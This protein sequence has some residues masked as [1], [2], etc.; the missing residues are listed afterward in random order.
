MVIGRFAAWLALV[1]VRLTMVAGPFHLEAYTPRWIDRCTCWMDTKLIA[2]CEYTM[3]LFR[4][5]GVSERRLALVYYGPDADRFDP[6]RT[7]PAPI[8]QQYRWAPNTPVIGM[9]AYFYPRFVPSRWTPPALWGRSTKGHEYLIRAM[10]QVLGEFPTA[11]CLLVGSGW[12][13]PG[14]KHMTEMR[15]LVRV[16]GLEESVVFAGFRA[17][18][19]SIL[20]A[21]D[22]SVQPSLSENL[23]GTIESLLMEC[24]TVATRVGGMPDSVRDGESG[25]LVA[26]ADPGDLARGILE[27]LRNPGRARELARNGRKLMLE[28]F[29]LRTTVDDLDGLYREGMA[30]AGN[31]RLHSRGARSLLRCLVAATVAAYLVLRL[32][33]VD[34]LWLRCWDAGRRRWHLASARGVASR[35]PRVSR[36]GLAQTKVVLWLDRFFAKFRGRL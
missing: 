30:R 22:V 15:E 27:L 29:T 13:A 17:D 6:S 10:P 26:P 3:R 25:V 24:P 31:Q 21:L 14:T 5:M 9:I 28:R 12:E 4:E 19:S 1:P 11:K 35:I 32:A 16:L 23:G 7:E 34:L 18:A 33:L 20:R 8:R 2:S 36:R